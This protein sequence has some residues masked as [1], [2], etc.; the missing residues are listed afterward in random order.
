MRKLIVFGLLMA[1][2]VMP[3]QAQ[4]GEPDVPD[5]DVPA[6]LIEQM[7]Q[8]T[9][10]AE[11]AA[12]R[13][14]SAA[15]E[16]AASA[17]STDGVVEEARE[18]LGLA[19]D[20]F[21]LF[22]AMSGLVTIILP[23]LAAVGGY[24]GFRRLNNAEEELREARERFEENLNQRSQELDNLRAELE[25]ATT[26]QR[27]HASRAS[28]AL[29]LLPVGDRQYR[30]QDYQGAL[31]TFHRALQLDEEN[32][33]THYRL[34]YVYTQSGELEL[35]KKHL[36]RSLELDPE[37]ASSQAALGYV[38]RRMGDKME[39][40]LERDIIYNQAE[41]KFLEALRRIPKL[42]D[43]DGES[44]WGSLGGLYRRRG[45]VDQAIRAY[46]QCGTVTPHSSYPFSNLALLFA[47][48]GE[49]QNMREMYVRVEEL[50]Q[51]E[52]RDEIDNYW[53]YADLLVSRLAQGKIDAAQETLTQVFRTSPV[54]SPYTLT[55]LVETLER[56]ATVLTPDERQPIYDTIA[57]INAVLAARQ[58]G[59]IDTSASD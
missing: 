20:M 8:L 36:T 43:E 2:L 42:M 34:G 46:Q 53:A 4:D 13:A 37:F 52:I 27:E 18:A 32:P 24:I 9:G 45:Q 35:A 16:A 1:L 40:G 47:N 33:A 39:P 25:R 11:Q 38:Y 15:V 49:I 22:E 58:A 6:E 55:S 48:K 14:E 10:Q 54:D 28:L 56:L 59:E 21:G 30:A 7:E 3:V 50:A 19:L 17:A 5:D 26:V 23:V 57:E 29:S 51:G 44:W 31:D 12:E 41:E